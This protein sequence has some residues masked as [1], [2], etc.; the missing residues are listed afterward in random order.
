MTEIETTRL[1][2][3]RL[4]VGDDLINDSPVVGVDRLDKPTLALGGLVRRPL[5]ASAGFSPSC[6]GVYFCVYS[7]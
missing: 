6:H 7:E 1:W 2:V 3:S 5:L 4:R